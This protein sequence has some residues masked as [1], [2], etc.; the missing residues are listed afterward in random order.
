M[1]GHLVTIADAEENQFVLSLGGAWDKWIGLRKTGATFTWVDK[2]PMNYE[3]WGPG[4]PDAAKEKGK[5]ESENAGVM[6]GNREN[7]RYEWTQQWPGRWNDLMGS[8]TNPDVKGYVCEW[9]Y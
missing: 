5:M 3:N 1:G 8:K 6:V 7:Q 4:Q 2:S 9:D